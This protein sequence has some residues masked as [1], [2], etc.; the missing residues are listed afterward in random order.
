MNFTG[1]EIIFAVVCISLVSS[2]IGG[3]IGVLLT[4]KIK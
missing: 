3:M 4:E 1:G 2:L